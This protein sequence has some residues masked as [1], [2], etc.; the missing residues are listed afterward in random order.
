MLFSKSAV[1]YIVSPPRK[2]LLSSNT[3]NFTIM[4]ETMKEKVE[5]GPMFDSAITAH[6][7]TPYL[8]D[9]DIL[10]DVPAIAPGGK[11]SYLAGRW[12]YRFTHCVL[13]E[14]TTN[15][16]DDIWRVSWTDE[17][18]DFETWKQAGE[19]EGF[20]WGVCWS[21]A[22]PGLSYIEK[23]ESAK[24]WSERLGQPMHEVVVE[25]NSQTLRLIFHDVDIREIARGNPKTNELTPL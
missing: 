11:T 9:Y 14:V 3:S 24:E 13:V 25:T 8:R 1:K 5:A 18:T 23:S 21:E 17:F 12:R 16:A 15:V 2:T 10:V 7:F 6:G 22:Y 19:P 20:V 4:P